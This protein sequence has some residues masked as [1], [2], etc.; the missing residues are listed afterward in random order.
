MTPT[1]IPSVQPSTKSPT[2]T[3]T[4]AP[5]NPFSLQYLFAKLE[6]YAGNGVAANTGD[7]GPATSAGLSRAAGLWM[8]GLNQMYIVDYFTCNVRLVSATGIINT[9]GGSST[10]PS[11]A[12]STN[13]IAPFTKPNNDLLSFIFDSLPKCCLYYVR[14]LFVLLESSLRVRFTSPN[15]SCN[16]PSASPSPLPSPP[17]LIP[18]PLNSISSPNLFYEMDLVVGSGSTSYNGDNLP[19]GTSTNVNSPAGIWVDSSGEVYF[20]DSQLCA[21]RRISLN[22]TVTVAGGT[23]G[24]CGWVNDGS[25]PFKLIKMSS[26]YGL[27]GDATGR[28]LYVSDRTRIWKYNVSSGFARRIAGKAGTFESTG[29]GGIAI[30]ATFYLIR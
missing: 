30:N 14:L 27:T 24:L 28:T 23:I 2:E 12:M 25:G 8:D 4:S 17:T 9:S 21:L 3:P 22:G 19:A 5:T 13:P 15:G 16:E 6:L 29:D 20:V 10:C 7:G 11:S 26:T 18:T 1:F